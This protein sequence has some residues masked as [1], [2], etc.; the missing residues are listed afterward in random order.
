MTATLLD[1][2]PVRGSSAGRDALVLSGLDVLAAYA[3]G[4]YAPPPFSYLT[5]MRIS[6]FRRGEVDVVLPASGWWLSTRGTV[7]PAV[8]AV[9]ADFPLNG[10]VHSVLPLG[11]LF[12]TA[13]LSLTF[14]APALRP[15]GVHLARGCAGSV[16]TRAAVSSVAVHDD[17]GRGV[18]SGKACLAVVPARQVAA[19]GAEVTPRRSDD[20]T[21]PHPFQRPPA[22]AVLQ[23]REA[24]RHSGLELL[25][26]R[27]DGGLDEPPISR[28]TGMRL[29]G[30]RAGM[31]RW[32][33]TASPWLASVLPGRMYGGWGALFAGLAM[34][35]ALE[36]LVP[37]G[38]QPALR[39]MS[40]R[41]H[42]AVPLD[43]APLAARAV[44]VWRGAA[45]E[46]AMRVEILDGRGRIALTAAGTGTAVA[47]ADADDL[48]TVEHGVALACSRSAEKRLD[49]PAA[50]LAVAWPSIQSRGSEGR[51]SR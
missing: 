27:L 45:S 17:R 41:F 46:A 22:G 11:S 13:Q 35:S 49:A 38:S 4:D 42:R 14:H 24:A 29:V 2:L 32:S 7:P 9:L 1:D 3:R 12:T 10:A 33:M 25:R 6:A 19:A 37:A 20:F 31:V 15:G 8:L 36:T 40:V 39:S 16:T 18:A 48:S 26:A 34:E 50:A 23:P 5:G 43:G 21:T 28:F 30:A 44:A 47:L 51:E